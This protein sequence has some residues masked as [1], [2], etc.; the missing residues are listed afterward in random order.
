MKPDFQKLLRIADM[1]DGLEPKVF[2]MLTLWEEA[3]YWENCLGVYEQCGTV[4]CMLGHASAVGILES[5]MCDLNL[6]NASE[7]LGLSDRCCDFLFDT[8]DLKGRT[9][10][11]EMPAQAA[12][13]VRKFIYYFLRK[14]ELLADDNSRYLGDVGVAGEVVEQL[15]GV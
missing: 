10:A 14:G 2:Q 9:R 5:P 4:G 6:E 12:A 8:F 3:A 7:E 13:R 11:W 1:T 15:A